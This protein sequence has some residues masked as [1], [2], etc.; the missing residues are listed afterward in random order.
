V[1]IPPAVQTRIDEIIQLLGLQA[2]P[3]ESL[4]IHFDQER[5]AQAVKP[6]LSFRRE[7][8]DPA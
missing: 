6:Q 8:R 1:T 4:S 5:L 2:L 3:L 7:K